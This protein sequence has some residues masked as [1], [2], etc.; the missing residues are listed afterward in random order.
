ME[1][2]SESALHESRDRLAILDK[3]KGESVAAHGRNTHGLR[4]S[5]DYSRRR[6]QI[7]VAGS[8]IDDI[9]SASDELAL[10]LRNSS[11]RVFG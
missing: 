11:E 8:E 1:I 6:R 4:D 10:F 7:G 5:L 9:H 3:T 2:L